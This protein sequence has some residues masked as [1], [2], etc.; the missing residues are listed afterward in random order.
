MS[1]APPGGPLRRAWG[2]SLDAGALAPL[3]EGARDRLAVRPADERGPW[4]AADARTT[5]EL[6]RRAEQDAPLPWPQPL[7]SHHARYFRDG[8]RTEYEERVAARQRRL[9]RA[10]VT[11]ASTGAQRWVDEAADGITLLCEQS[12]WCWAAHDDTRDVHGAVVPTVTSPYLDL[13]AGE[14]AAQLA[15]ADHVL[16]PLLDERVPGLRTRV[17]HEFRLRVLEPFT[18]RRD[19]HWLGLDGDVHN[20][21]P[22]IHSNLVAAAL[23]LLDDPGERAR[24]VALA[25]EGLDRF[26]AA[27]P[28]DGAVDEGWSYWWNGAGRALECLDLLRQASGGRLDASGIP[29]VRETVRFPHRMHLGGDWYLNVGDGTARPRQPLPW[30][31]LH[32]W[33]RATGDADATRH[34]AWQRG[35]TATVADPDASLGRVLTALADPAWREAAA[36]TPPL[37]RSA[38]LPSVE[39]LL[40][41]EEPGAERGLTLTVKGGHDGEHHNHLDVG[42]VVV[43]L[44][45]APV[46]VDAGQPTYTA[47]TFSPRRYE[48]RAMRSGWH[49]V[50]VPWGLEQGQGRT[51]RATGVR[52][53]GGDAATGLELELAG[54]YD[55]PAGSTWRRWARLENGA[56]TPDGGFVAISEAWSLA[57]NPPDG[58]DGTG[59]VENAV[60]HLLAGD[61]ELTGT[62]AVV[63]RPGAR[64][65]LLHWSAAP[66]TPVRAALTPWELD[67]PLL[68]AVWGPRLT[69]LELRCGPAPTGALTVLLRAGGTGHGGAGA[70]GG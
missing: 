39:V 68:R 64:E 47:L 54:A 65:L 44:D 42:S 67:D 30:D 25:V 35:R 69:R 1:L 24:T 58:A 10:V 31:V 18:T 6:R 41:R 2:T 4:S 27:L 5:A 28:P 53:T 14:V 60:H 55:L 36:D 22:W 45:G 12:S 66:G 43:A 20:W 8:N 13:G 59:D 26:L 48:I 56:G 70:H 46:L 7:T 33:G 21:N 34:A 52:R 9:T 49:N 29:V 19:W 38:W 37:V 32:R 3:L 61:V 17:R 11:A 63:R 50:P 40:T 16:G 57:G 23:L 15:W 62:S 51:Y